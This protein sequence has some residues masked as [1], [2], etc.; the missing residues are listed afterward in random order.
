MCC[1]CAVLAL[2]R[3]LGWVNT[4]ALEHIMVIKKVRQ[5][6][7]CEEVTHQSTLLP[8][9]CDCMISGAKYLL[10]V[11]ISQQYT[12][13]VQLSTSVNKY[14]H[15]INMLLYFVVTALSALQ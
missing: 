9:P 7:V 6:E 3:L 15:D 10:H 1:V 2:R 14:T 8:W 11:H 4:H 5:F 13:H 12:P